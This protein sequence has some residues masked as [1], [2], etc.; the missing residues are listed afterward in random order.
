ML[1]MVV[2][3]VYHGLWILVEWYKMVMYV[4]W[5]MFVDHGVFGI[6]VVV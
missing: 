1:V 6:S 5:M 4:F 2:V 3:L